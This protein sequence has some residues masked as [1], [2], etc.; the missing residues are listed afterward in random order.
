MGGQEVPRYMR[1][2]NGLLLSRMEA[3]YNCL[4]EDLIAGSPSLSK[5]LSFDRKKLFKRLRAEGI[6]LLTSTL[7]RLGKAV[8]AGFQSGTFSC[9]VGF[10][11]RGALPRFL[12][13]LLSN[14]FDESTGALTDNACAASVDE[15]LQVCM[16]CY[17]LELPYSAE[18]NKQVL[19]KFI[20][21]DQSLPPLEVD[22]VVSI[23]RDIIG[24]IFHGFDP[25]DIKP[26]H[27]PGAVA[28]GEK[29]ERKWAFS[30]KYDRIHRV[31]PYYEYFVPSRQS[32][33]HH[34]PRY[35]ELD[36]QEYGI[37]RV[38]LVPKDSRGP[39]LISME[40][41][42]YQFI[43]QGLG[44]AIMNWLESS[45]ITR[46]WVNFTSQE[47]NQELALKITSDNLPLVTVDLSEASDRV[48]LE[49]VTYLFGKCP[50]LI[51]SLLATR[52]EGTL[53][54]DEESTFVRFKKFAPMGSMLCFP[55]QAVV[56][57]ALIRA[58]ERY[59]H[60]P[61]C[62]YVFGDD[63]IVHQQTYPHLVRQFS[64]LGMQVNEG[65]CFT[66]GPF[67]ESCGMDAFKGVPVTYTKLRRI[68]PCD[69]RDL[70]GLLASSKL[71]HHLYLRGY[72]R[73]SRYVESVVRQ[74]IPVRSF[75]PLSGGSPGL[76]FVRCTRASRKL[77][78]DD[79]LH[80]LLERRFVISEVTRPRDEASLDRVDGL[81]FQNLV[82]QKLEDYAVPH[83]AKLS[84]RWVPVGT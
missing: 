84:M 56:Y 5:D 45:P 82:E 25:M 21:T 64:K 10:Q 2:H 52:T 11:K 41:L 36:K 63:I 53:L 33:L 58:L 72:W 60:L 9:P 79:K 34:I 57:F 14:V 15:V 42:E 37:A 75:E 73:T 78:W 8:L 46:G 12:G 65:K 28:T 61:T 66:Q 4:F 26:Q 71:Q 80:R 31:Y 38:C 16:L 62:S 67:R 51:K 30:R 68:L 70:K 1:D 54:P 17:K 44:R 76:F 7:P 39:R 81:L 18:Q 59:W 74:L 83:A 55:V 49:L 43:Q 23:A 48:S 40:P 35:R 3:L 77:R 22:S 6:T 32:L 24:E 47:V 20:A 29:D 13:G 50:K 19:D 69:K 27:G